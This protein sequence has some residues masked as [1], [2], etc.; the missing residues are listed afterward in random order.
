MDY[1]IAKNHH[2]KEKNP[3]DDNDD[4]KSKDHKMIIDNGDDTQLIQR[5]EQ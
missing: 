3:L 4:S 5:T 1:L 2:R